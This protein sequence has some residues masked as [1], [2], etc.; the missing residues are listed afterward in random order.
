MLNVIAIYTERDIS[1][2]TDCMKHYTYCR[3]LFISFYPLN[4][5]SSTGLW[6]NLSV[7]AASLASTV[8]TQASLQS[9]D[10]AWQVRIVILLILE[11]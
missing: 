9:P 10:P 5:V 8:Q 2:I 1:V 4:T 7:A 3:C 6:M 11:V